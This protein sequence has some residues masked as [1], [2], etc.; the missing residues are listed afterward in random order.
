MNT[1]A[2]L[3]WEWVRVKSLCFLGP[4]LGAKGNTDI[5]PQEMHRK[6]NGL[7]DVVLWFEAFGI[8]ILDFLSVAFFGGVWGMTSSDFRYAGIPL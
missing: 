3:S 5:K 2:G 6:S 7:R 8:K 4:C 1:F